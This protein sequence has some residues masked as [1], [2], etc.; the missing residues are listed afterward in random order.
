M[1]EAL[2]A[3]GSQHAASLDEPPVPEPAE[4]TGT[5]HDVIGAEEQGYGLVE[6]SLSL[7]AASKRL[8]AQHRRVLAM[9][10]SE[11]LKQREIAGRIG[12]SQMQ[13]SR[14][15][16]RTNVQLVDELGLTPV[17][18]GN[19]RPSRSSATTT[20]IDQPRTSH[21]SASTQTTT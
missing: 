1:I 4:D 3:I 14:I 8:P 20:S 10:F 15:L 16:R 2:D 17:T 9:R 21:S 6:T 7:A 19:T 12:I 13:V 11:E 18:A 5:R